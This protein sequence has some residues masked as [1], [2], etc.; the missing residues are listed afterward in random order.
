MLS[1]VMFP[2]LACLVFQNQKF[3]ANCHAGVTCIHALLEKVHSCCPY[4]IMEGG[5]K[6][7]AFFVICALFV[8]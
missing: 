5:A 8:L 1:N 3:V 6:A 2:P 4:R 7:A